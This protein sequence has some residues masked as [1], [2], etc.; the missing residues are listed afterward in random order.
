M[1]AIRPTVRIFGTEKLL[2]GLLVVA[3]FIRLTNTCEAERSTPWR[4]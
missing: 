3:M 1:A 2:D 4:T